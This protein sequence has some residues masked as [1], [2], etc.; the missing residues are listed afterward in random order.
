M[1]KDVVAAGIMIMGVLEPGRHGLLLLKI[2]PLTAV[3]EQNDK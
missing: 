2:K 3:I 1:I